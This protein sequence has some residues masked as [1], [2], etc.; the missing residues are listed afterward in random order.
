MAHN[1]K[2]GDRGLGIWWG[3]QVV[4]PGEERLVLLGGR[5]SSSVGGF[6]VLSSINLGVNG[7]HSGPDHRYCDTQASQ[8]NRSQRI[9]QRRETYPDFDKGNRNSG[10]RRPQ[11]QKQK[12]ARKGRD[13]MEEIGCQSSALR[14]VRGAEVK[15]NRARHD[16]LQQ[17]TSAR[18]A[19]GECGK[20]TL[21]T[22]PP[23]TGLMLV[24]S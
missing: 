9:A 17:K 6:E 5:T 2:S 13:Q 21:Q 4:L 7:P 24:D 11:A 15:Q 8:H 3:F 14:K 19:F 12:Y 22:R 18:P 23:I 1:G 10:Y 16:T 20:Q